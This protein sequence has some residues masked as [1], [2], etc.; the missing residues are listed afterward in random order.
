V[1][2]NIPQTYPPHSFVAPD[3]SPPSP[4]AQTAV[5]TATQ[6]APK[7]P[8][9]VA[10]HSSRLPRSASWSRQRVVNLP[11]DVRPGRAPP[12]S[13][14]PGQVWEPL[15]PIGAWPGA[16]MRAPPT[17][18]GPW[19]GAAVPPPPPSLAVTTVHAPTPAYSF[20]FRRESNSSML[21]PCPLRPFSH[22]SPHLM[23]HLLRVSCASCQN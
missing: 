22:K 14:T 18:L 10:R 5:T 15:E 17:L 4:T 6:P 1:F 12:N 23:I 11:L 16:T 9:E 13:S 7:R 3:S 21:S 20:P 2:Y 8:G 19:W